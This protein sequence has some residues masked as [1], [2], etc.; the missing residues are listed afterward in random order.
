MKSENEKKLKFHG[1]GQITSQGKKFCSLKR[2][3][4]VS[5]W[6]VTSVLITKSS[7][8]TSLSCLTVTMITRSSKILT[9]SHYYH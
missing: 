6:N 8:C 2:K 4:S 5:N 9:M 7:E 3:L 1:N